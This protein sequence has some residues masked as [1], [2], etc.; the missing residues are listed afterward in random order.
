MYLDFYV[1]YLNPSYAS[2]RAYGLQLR[3]LPDAQGGDDR[4]YLFLWSDFTRATDLD[5]PLTGTFPYYSDGVAG[6]KYGAGNYK[7]TN[8]RLY[9]VSTS[10]AG[11]PLAW[12]PAPGHRGHGEGALWYVGHHGYSWASA[13]NKT[14]S[15]F[16][17]FDT[18]GI[19]TSYSD[20]RAHG[21]QL[22]CLSE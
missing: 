13:V 6:E 11:T 8:G 3:C 19:T 16:L 21:L 15:L 17:S 14:N 1:T 4:A 10:G 9:K 5:Q 12:Y 7:A 20:Y 2:S 18:R 22:R